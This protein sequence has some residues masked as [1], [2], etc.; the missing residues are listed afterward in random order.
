MSKLVMIV[1]LLQVLIAP[2]PLF[3]TVYP[4]VADYEIDASFFPKTASLVALARVR[5]DPTETV[6][7]SVVFYLHSELRIDSIR[8]AEARIKYTEDL[9]L[10]CYNYSG[11]ANRVSC[12]FE[13]FDSGQPLEI[14]Y[15]GKMNPSVATSPS[16]YMRI[17]SDGVFL[18]AYAYSLWFP[19]F[20]KA[21]QQSYTT[22]FSDVTIRAPKG[23][24]SIFVGDRTDQYL[25]NDQSVSTW[26]ARGVDLFEAQ[27]SS[28]RYAEIT[29]G[30]FHVFCLKDSV[31]IDRGSEIL[32][33]TRWM[34]GRMSERF[35][36]STGAGQIHV[37]QMPKFG[38]IA[39]GNVT[40]MADRSWSNFS[41]ESY[42][43][44][45]LAHELVHA[46]VQLPISRDDPLYAFV[47]EG[48]PSHFDAQILRE[49][50]GDKWLSDVLV[51]TEAS[52]LKKK[53][54]GKNWRG[55]ILPPEKP[56]D[57]IG[58]DEIG[59]YKDMFVIGERTS[60]FFNWL[61]IKLGLVAYSKFERELFD[62]PKLTDS[63]FRELVEKHLPGSANDI[64]IWL[65]TNDYPER[66]WLSNL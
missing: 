50:R 62:M 17:D 55:R 65:S 36:R 59:L 2:R 58:P 8:Q 63:S 26:T 15:N 24:L 60:L 12:Q 61:E 51:R 5:F 57:Q 9:V 7:D 19:V 18:R 40:G 52:Y 4:R 29:E 11:V 25:E 1:V 54:T 10:Y 48:F 37:M 56:I 45:S 46:F 44:G 27:C 30:P 35:I 41:A 33:L 47:V 13:L 43:V 23:F 34:A 28:R 21:K 16:N 39:S 22:N 20:L 31:S 66:F 32:R 49:K 38:D 53:K 64:R 3:A 14:W 42:S 6:S